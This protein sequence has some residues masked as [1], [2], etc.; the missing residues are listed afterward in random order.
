MVWHE[1][2]PSTR[3]KFQI[4]KDMRIKGADVKRPPGMK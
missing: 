2:N 1:E 3:R 4:Q